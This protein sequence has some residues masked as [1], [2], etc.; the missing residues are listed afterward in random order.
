MRSVGRQ[1]PISITSE[2]LCPS[3][4]PSVKAA[5][6]L[7]A[8]SRELTVS[9]IESINLRFINA[10][11]VVYRAGFGG[12][13]LHCAHGYLLSQFLSPKTNRRDDKYGGSPDRRRYLLHGLIKSIRSIT[14]P[15]FMISVKLNSADFQKGGLSLDESL[16][17]VEMLEADGIDLLEVSGGTYEDA[18]MINGVDT[19]GAGEL[20]KSSIAREAFF[21]SYVQALRCRFPELTVPVMLTG[22]FRSGAGMVTALSSGN[23]DVV[24]L[25][26]PFATEPSAVARLV[27]PTTADADLFTLQLPSP[28]LGIPGLNALDAGIENLWHQKQIQLISQGGRPDMNLNILPCLGAQMF[29]TYVWNPKRSS[30]FGYVKMGVVCT[31]L[32]VCVGKALELALSLL[33]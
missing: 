14:S 33:W 1:C 23:V 4:N 15:N 27:A 3:A 28:K 24:G 12:V 29:V 25:G 22:G 30:T 21:L 6:P 17:V 2:P 7:F 26:R 31:V 18:A 11:H 9:E 5:L 8:S 19:G 32:I 10:A 13:Q 20:P 16:D